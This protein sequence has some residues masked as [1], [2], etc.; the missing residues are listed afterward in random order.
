MSP[1]RNSNFFVLPALLILVICGGA[2]SSGSNSGPDIDNPFVPT[3]SGFEL[4]RDRVQPRLAKQCGSCHSGRRFAFA[5]IQREGS[6]FT[7]EETITNYAVFRAMISLD[8]PEQSRLLAKLL[9]TTHPVSIPH[10]GGVLIEQDDATYS[11]FLEWI[12]T[13]KYYE[14]PNCGL[15]ADTAYVAYLDHD[16]THWAIDR[17]PTRTDRSMRTGARIMLQPM[18]AAEMTPRGPPIE[19]L[20]ASF[21]GSDGMC[22]WG[23]MSANYAGTQLAF[24]CRLNPG[25]NDI[26]WLDLNWNICIA[27]I[28]FD[29]KAVNPRFLRNV[30]RHQ[31]V[32]IARK[33]PLGLLQS[34]GRALYGVYDD[35]VATR[36]KNDLFPVFSW[37]NNR[38]YF[39][40][41]SADPRTKVTGTRTYHGFEH[42]NNIISSDLEGDDL[43]SI[44]VNEGGTASDLTFLK[45]GNLAIHVWNL[46][47]M[48]RHLYIQS[49]ADGMMEQPV[50]FGRLQGP[51]MW[52]A[53]TQLS[54]GGLVGMTGLR[55]GSISSFVPFF[56]DHTIGTGIDEAF[57]SFTVLDPEIVAEMD[58]E[59]AYCVDP[60]EGKNCHT[61]RFYD[62]PSYAPDGRAL[63]T[64]HPRKTYYS[65]SESAD[66]FWQNYGGSADAI[67]AFVPALN[68]SLINFRGE[69]SPLLVPPKGRSFRYPTWVG[70]REAPIPQP[71]ITDETKD[72]AELHIANVPIWFSFQRSQGKNK[73][74]LL[75]RLHSIVSLRILTKEMSGNACTNDGNPYRR[76]V[77]SGYDHPTHLGI[78]NATGYRKYRVPGSLGG[79]AFGDIPLQPDGS[80]RVVLPAGKLLLFQGV[81]ANGFLVAQH[82]R[83]FALPP[84]HT[85][86]T[87]VKRGQYNAQCAACHGA[88]DG[89]SYVGVGGFDQL[90]ASMDFETMAT[91]DKAVDI[92]ADGVTEQLLTFLAQLR[93]ILDDKCVSCH[94]ADAPEGDLTLVREYSPIANYPPADSRW[95]GQVPNG[96]NI[97][98]GDRVYG[99]TWSSSR[100]F[101]IDPDRPKYREAYIAPDDPHRPLGNLA[102]WD[103]GYQALFLRSGGKHYYLDNLSSPHQLGRGG[104]FARESYLLEVLSGVDYNPARDFGGPDHSQYLD[105]AQLRTL[106]SVID[107]GF[108]YMSRCD[109]KLVPSGPN[110]GKPWGDPVEK[111]LP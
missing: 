53:M 58:D 7:E 90:E 61:S 43:R 64:H 97:P 21:C 76:A 91:P 56:A 47:R 19:F 80:A 107:N 8:A 73:T 74:T 3:S 45:N 100:T 9:P 108:P 13:E 66:Q 54:N 31:G 93:P 84:G 29:G 85:I 33:N 87:S 40:S 101:M 83:V 48:D 42:T 70:M 77:W 49:S 39:S 67:A 86:D 20:D 17:S 104:P 59:F 16:A 63:I 65:S 88:I 11:L 15:T 36:K 57:S 2:S 22:D 105:E 62:D 26:P 81:D 38:V 12:N 109:D 1:F 75:N 34:N 32:S 50:L 82:S 41:R 94:N 89:A 106:S 103:P 98:E 18:D 5:S 68:V 10:G 79:D 35:Q 60:P 92:T 44:Y 46:E 71:Q 110:F 52:G 14:C 25:K 111:D 37:D 30:D 55:R 69:V 51:N 96:Y 102:P 78:N 4:F 6:K 28:G 72:T 95:A 24:E 27:E 99:F 23:R